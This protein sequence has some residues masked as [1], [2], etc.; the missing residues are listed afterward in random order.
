MAERD[1]S[2]STSRIYVGRILKGPKPA[3]LPIVQAQVRAR[4]QP[5]DRQQLG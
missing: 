4:H 1:R 3:D 5:D 2:I